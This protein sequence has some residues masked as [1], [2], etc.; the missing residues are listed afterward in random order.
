MKDSLAHLPELTAKEL[1]YLARCVEIFC[2]Q[3]E[4]S[5]ETKMESFIASKNAL[6]SFFDA[7]EF[8]RV[9]VKA[10]FLK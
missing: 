8:E 6:I 5:C 4:A 1:K 3:T 9:V 7:A 10:L 2:D